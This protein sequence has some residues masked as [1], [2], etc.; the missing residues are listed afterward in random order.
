MPC[1]VRFD[2]KNLDSREMSCPG[3]LNFASERQFPDFDH[4]KKS[5]R[6]GNNVPVTLSIVGRGMLRD[7]LDPNYHLKRLCDL[8]RKSASIFFFEENFTHPKG[9]SNV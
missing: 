5:P 2:R 6:T 9:L 1:F 8:Q 7:T 4:Q 3:N